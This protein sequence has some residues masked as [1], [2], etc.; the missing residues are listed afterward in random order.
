VIPLMMK[1]EINAVGKQFGLLVPLK[2]HRRA[3]YNWRVAHPQGDR[4]KSFRS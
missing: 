1:H 2:V 4:D 3:G